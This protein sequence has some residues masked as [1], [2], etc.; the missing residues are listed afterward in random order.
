MSDVAIKPGAKKPVLMPLTWYSR[1][2]QE[3]L[4]NKYTSSHYWTGQYTT[5]FW[6]RLLAIAVYLALPVSLIAIT[7]WTLVGYAAI[8]AIPA[9]HAY[10]RRGIS[11][12]HNRVLAY[13]SYAKLK[14]GWKSHGHALYTQVWNHDC[15]GSKINGRDQY[16]EVWDDKRR[17]Y[18]T[19]L[20]SNPRTH[21]ECEH[22]DKRI[23]EL[24]KLLGSQRQISDKLADSIGSELISASESFRK[25]V[26][27]AGERQQSAL[28]NEIQKSI[29]S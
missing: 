24:A 21:V 15:D 19:K 22:C 25:A 8:L 27:E 1:Q 9:S 13:N 26:T 23:V 5:F 14:D 17:R 6:L 20:V 3:V 18:V 10:A 7:L 2:V 4:D 29:S 28:M 11:R 12:Q 16:D